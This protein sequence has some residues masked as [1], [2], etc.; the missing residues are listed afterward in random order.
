[1]LK[2]PE[3]IATVNQLL[4]R[5]G[6]NAAENLKRL[7]RDS[8]GMDP[9]LLDEFMSKPDLVEKL[10]GNF[11]VDPQ[12]LKTLLSKDSRVDLEMLEAV[13][14]S[15]PVENL[16]EM[17][18]FSPEKHNLN[19]DGIGVLFEKD[20]KSDPKLIEKLFEN[21]KLFNDLYT[22]GNNDPHVLKK[23]V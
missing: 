6:V 20:R 19:F 7:I 12:L 17:F 16:R 13:I 21:P 22:K 11:D 18:E 23:L 10:L 3:A 14:M 4:E 15:A 8:P 9:K 2:N 1:M 5:G